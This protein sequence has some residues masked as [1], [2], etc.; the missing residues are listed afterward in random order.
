VERNRR[1]ARLALAGHLLEL[2]SA[3][4][5]VLTADVDHPRVDDARV[6][7]RYARLQVIRAAGLGRETRDLLS[8]VLAGAAIWAVAVVLGDLLGL[9]GGWTVAITVPVVLLGLGVPVSRLLEAIDR[10]IGRRRTARTAPP[11]TPPPGVGRAGETLALLRLAR[12]ELT[13]L[14][15]ERS[16]GHPTAGAFDRLRLRDRRLTAL[17]AADRDVC[18]AIHAITI[19]LSVA[20]A[21]ADRSAGAEER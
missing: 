6:R 1:P 13:V 18:V 20:E 11:V 19:W 7:L 14:M 3:R 12:R 2:A 17:S 21:A 9:P 8:V 10:W 16:A 4:L 5:E 15:R